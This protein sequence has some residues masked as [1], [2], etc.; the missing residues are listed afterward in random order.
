MERGKKS[1]E[2]VHWIHLTAKPKLRKYKR[3]YICQYRFKYLK[4]WK[5]NKPA[6][7]RKDKLKLVKRQ[8]TK[9]NMLSLTHKKINEKSVI[10]PFFTY[11]INKDQRVWSYAIGEKVWDI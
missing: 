5:C 2:M 4:H 7:N 1:T 8:M 9:E 10:F 11:Q 3:E 6:T